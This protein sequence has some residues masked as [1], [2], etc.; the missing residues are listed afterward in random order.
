MFSERGMVWHCKHKLALCEKL[1]SKEPGVLGKVYSKCFQEGL[2]K[3][4]LQVTLRPRGLDCAETIAAISW[5]WRLLLFLGEM[6]LIELQIQSSF[7]TRESKGVGEH[8][9]LLWKKVSI[10]RR[11]GRI[12]QLR[13]LQREV[14]WGRKKRIKT[15]VERLRRG[16]S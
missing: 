11:S 14:F 1:P 15:A 13:K 2:P 10:S 8:H 4:W 6:P 12:I 5:L 16:K 7:P 9:P 3:D